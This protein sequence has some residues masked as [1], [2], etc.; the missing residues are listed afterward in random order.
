MSAVIVC[1]LRNLQENR[2]GELLNE[3]VA[4]GHD[5][6][7]AHCLNHCI[8]CRKG[9]SLTMDG[10]WIGASDQAELRQAMGFDS[11]ERADEDAGHG[12]R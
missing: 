3:L 12:E 9:P 10:Q 11:Q 1:C 8:G 5:V 4:A 7:L 6:S 2:H